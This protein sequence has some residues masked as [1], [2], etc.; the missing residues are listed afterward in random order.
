MRFLTFFIILMNV[1][2]FHFHRRRFEVPNKI[3]NMKKAAF[4]TGYDD[5]YRRA[6][7]RWI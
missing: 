3:E 4:R 6:V 7:F 1:N 5:N 2:A